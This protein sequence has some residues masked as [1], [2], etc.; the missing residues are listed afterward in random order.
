MNKKIKVLHILSSNKYSGAE[1]VACTII[2]HI[3]NKY[4]MI[5]CSPEGP[6]ENVLKTKGINYFPIKSFKKRDLQKVVN[7]FKPDIIHAHDNKATILAARLNYKCKKIS[8]IHGNNKILNTIN[9]KTLIF[10]YFS[11]YIDFFIWVS[12]SALNDYYFKDNI[13]SKSV[14]L[15]NVVD[16]NEIIKKSKL[17]SIDYRFDLIYLGRLGYPKNPRRLLKIISMLKQKKNDISVAIVGDGPEREYMENYIS[18][19]NLDNNIKMFGYKSNPYPIL[20]K[21]KILIM[22]SIYEG[23]PMCALEAQALGKPIVA[24]PVDGL[25][26][27]VIDGY[28]GFLTND[29]DDFVD[30]IL[31]ALD[32]NYSD[33]VIKLFDDN[34]NINNYISKIE[35]I[36]K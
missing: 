20:S 18:D 23:T 13:I 34:N 12:D 22:T 33:N 24:T 2:K 6:I 30:K 17:E 29:D 16:K 27:I 3:N 19:N 4:E 21:S 5:Y 36:Y 26:K 32:N 11:K 28:N 15:Y 25:K 9:I 1:N 31:L 8:H 14:V 10:N 35:D 7:D